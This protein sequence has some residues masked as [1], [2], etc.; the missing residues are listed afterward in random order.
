MS[1]RES[2][3]REYGYVLHQRPYKNSSQLLECFTLNHGRVGLVA[4]GSR[5]SGRGQRA[6]L[7]AFVPLRFYWVRRGELGRLVQVEADTCGGLALRGNG[8]LAAYYVNELIMALTARDDANPIVYARYRDCLQ[9]LASDAHVAR[10][11]RVF[12]LELLQGLG[13]GLELGFEADNRQPVEPEKRYEVDF[14]NGPREVSGETGY[15]GRELISLRDHVLDDASSL[16]AA[17]R[18]LGRVLDAHLGGRKL[19][20]RDV[21]RDI[22]DRGLEV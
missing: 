22:V 14:E 11:L 1:A 4:Q 10:T 21:L 2:V 19:R 18:L 5:R 7:Q 9:R 12:E 17:R 16:Q 15:L 8:L 6:L 13:Y 20:S 3:E